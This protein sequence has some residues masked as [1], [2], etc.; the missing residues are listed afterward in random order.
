VVRELPTL[1]EVVRD[2]V[3]LWTIF[4]VY[5]YYTHRLFHQPFFYQRFH[6]KHHEFT[7][8]I[9]N[10]TFYLHP[11]ELLVIHL[12]VGLY[13]PFFYGPHVLTGI[14]YLITVEIK[15]VT[16]HSGYATPS[17]YPGWLFR[18]DPRY[19]DYHHEAFN[20]NFGMIGVMD[21]IHGTGKLPDPN[22]RPKG[23][24]VAN[25]KLNSS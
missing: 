14:L 9:A 12:G 16:E 13:I 21:W 24:K 25:A 4:E 23:D 20:C 19:H 6:K 22:R 8:P 2:L 5:F 3:V 18:L 11:F 1:Y 10:T 7:S 15:S 17:W